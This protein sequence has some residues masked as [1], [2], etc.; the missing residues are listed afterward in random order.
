MQLETATD[1]APVGDGVMTAIDLPEALAAVRL[2]RWFLETARAGAYETE[3]GRPTS[4]GGITPRASVR[5][6][7][8]HGDG[9]DFGGHREGENSDD[10][11]LRGLWFFPL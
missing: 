9:A 8:M 10:G 11:E 2:L 1:T 5:S 6:G 4:A 3:S 7:G